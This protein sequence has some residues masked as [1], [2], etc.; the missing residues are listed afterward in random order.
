LIC[1]PI[2]FKVSIVTGVFFAPNFRFRCFRNTDI[3]SVFGVI[4]F[5]FVSDKKYENGNDFSVYRSF[6]T[7]FTLVI[8]KFASG[9]STRT[10]GEWRSTGAI[11]TGIVK[12]HMIDWCNTTLM[13]HTSILRPTLNLDKYYDADWGKHASEKHE[14]NGGCL[15]GL[16][17][18]ANATYKVIALSPV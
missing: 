6:S 3:V 4:V 7:V 13:I 5:D 15:T 14:I 10:R 1:L 2:V 16:S 12:P 18:A 17:S 9:S 8:M 11:S